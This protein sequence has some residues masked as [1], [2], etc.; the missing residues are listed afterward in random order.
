MTHIIQL[1]SSAAAA[2]SITT[3]LADDVV[4]RLQGE[5]PDATVSVRDLTDLPV[6]DNARLVA[7]NTPADQRTPEQHELAAI[8]DE[9]VAEIHAADV[10]VIGVPIYNFGVPSSLKA[11]MDLA[12]RAGSTFRY[13]DDGPKGLVTGTRAV[14]AISS[15]GVGLRSE[16]DH[17]TAHLETFLTFLGIEHVDI[18]DATGLLFDPTG[19]DRARTQIA[20]LSAA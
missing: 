2:D 13:T 1:T 14:V 18:I 19:A 4:A 15:G 3:S 12:A 11:W 5:H 17:A 10:L 6:L 20:E 9:I 16:A 7:N 8:A